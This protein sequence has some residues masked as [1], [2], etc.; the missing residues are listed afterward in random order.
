MKQRKW[1]REW[2][3]ASWQFANGDGQAHGSFRRIL[4]QVRGG[5][6][7]ST[8]NVVVRRGLFVDDVA[9]VDVIAS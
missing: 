1:G 5:E 8:Q 9:E 6:T 3:V 7:K 4:A 2:Q